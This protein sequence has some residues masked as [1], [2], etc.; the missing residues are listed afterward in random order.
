M[1]PLGWLGR[2]TSTQ[3]N[4]KVLVSFISKITTALRK[5]AIIQKDLVILNKIYLREM[6]TLSW[7]A[8]KSFSSTL[9]GGLP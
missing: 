2:K 8:M 6:D 1:T 4:K 7:E 9:K 3:T 5:S